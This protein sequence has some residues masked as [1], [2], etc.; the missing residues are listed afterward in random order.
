MKALSATLLLTLV[1]T[2]A[3]AHRP[4]GIS[5]TVTVKDFDVHDP[6]STEK[7]D[8]GDI[9]HVARSETVGDFVDHEEEIFTLTEHGITF[10]HSDHWRTGDKAIAGD[11]GVTGLRLERRY[12]NADYA[13]WVPIDPPPALTG[14]KLYRTVT[15]SVNALSPRLLSF[16]LVGHGATLVLPDPDDWGDA[17]PLI[18]LTSRGYAVKMVIVADGGTINGSATLRFGGDY[19]SRTITVAGGQYVVTNSANPIQSTSAD[20][21]ADGFESGGLGAWIQ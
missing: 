14:G 11:Y 17:L 19:A 9:G 15:L 16:A 12:F 6:A 7:W 8:V 3:F 1:A 18:F 2:C 5:L 10:F 4:P 20:V 13:S 21:F